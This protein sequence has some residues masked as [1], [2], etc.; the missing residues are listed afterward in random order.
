MQKGRAGDALAHY[1]A[2]VSLDPLLVAAQVNLANA[3]LQAGRRDEALGHYRRAL[4]LDPGNQAAR[5]NLDY[6]L[7][8]PK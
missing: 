3:L 7:S 4:E 8:H 1:Q 6:A 2:A 5:S